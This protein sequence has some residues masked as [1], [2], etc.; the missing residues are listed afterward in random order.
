MDESSNIAT[1][2]Q[3]KDILATTTEHGFNMASEVKTGTLL[4]FLRAT[5]PGGRFLELGTGTDLATSWM[6]DGMDSEACLFSVDLIFADAWDGKYYHL[7][8]TINLL[9][10]G[11]IYIIDDILPRPNWPEG[12]QDKANV[13]ITML[14]QR[15]DLQIVKMCWAS[16]IIVGIKQ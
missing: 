3:L 10:Q 8:E 16:G 12:H 14:E 1:P 9:K 13:L 4:R 11:G 15:H 2:S 7:N 5:K 6:L